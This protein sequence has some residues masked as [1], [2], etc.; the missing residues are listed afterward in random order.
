MHQIAMQGTAEQQIQ[1]SPHVVYNAFHA[2]N[3]GGKDCGFLFATLLDI[4]HVIRKRIVEWLAK[5]VLNYFTDKI[6]EKLDDLAIK[7]KNN[8]H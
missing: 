6:K 2:V 7:F 1:Y 8:H 3:F 5:T 4:L